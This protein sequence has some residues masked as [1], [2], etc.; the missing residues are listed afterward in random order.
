MSADTQHAA[1]IAQQAAAA[2]VLAPERGLPE[3]AQHAVITICTP[4]NAMNAAALAAEGRVVQHS[5]PE[6]TAPVPAA[7]AATPSPPP[8]AA[9]AAVSQDTDVRPADTAGVK[10][11]HPEITAH[12]CALK[13]RTVCSAPE[14]SCQHVAAEQ[15]LHQNFSQ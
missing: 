3:T 13:K 14:M 9:A 11:E 15:L 10:N 5:T 4:H 8:P 7:V 2:A 12:T 6:C 1:R